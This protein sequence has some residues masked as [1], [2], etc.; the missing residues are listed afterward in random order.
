[1]LPEAFGIQLGV[2]SPVFIADAGRY[3]VPTLSQTSHKA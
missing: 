1:M 3:S 2:E